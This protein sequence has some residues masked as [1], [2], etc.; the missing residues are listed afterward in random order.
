MPTNL[1][2]SAKPLVPLKKSEACSLKR[3]FS[4][5][6]RQVVSYL[7]ILAGNDPDRFVWIRVG[8]IVKHCKNYAKKNND[9]KPTNYGKSAVEKALKDLRDAGILSY[10]EKV[11]LHIRRGYTVDECFVLAPHAALTVREEDGC[12]MVGP[13]RAPGTTWAA[14]KGNVWYVEKGSKN[15]L[16]STVTFTVGSTVPSTDR[17]MDA[18]TVQSTD[19]ST[20]SNE[21]NGL[22]EYGTEYGHKSGDTVELTEN[23]VEVK[24]VFREFSEGERVPNPS[25]QLV[26]EPREPKEP[27]EPGEPSRETG[28]HSDTSPSALSPHSLTKGGDDGVE[29]N[30]IAQRTDQLTPQETVAQVTTEPRAEERFVDKPGLAARPAPGGT[31]AEH[32]DRAEVFDK[33]ELRYLQIATDGLLTLDRK[34]RDE[35]QR[36]EGAIREAV[37]LVG[38]TP[39]VGRKSLVE[40]LNTAINTGRQK[41]P[42]PVFKVM[43]ELQEK[44]GDTSFKVIPERRDEPLPSGM[45]VYTDGVVEDPARLAAWV[46]FSE[47]D[48]AMGLNLVERGEAFEKIWRE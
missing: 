16:E 30:G 39:M 9:G 46:A 4:G 26:S 28:G 21:K 41:L 5:C 14:I 40:V 31:V 48:A 35:Y 45:V 34:H 2:D 18:S 32:F 33:W 11:Q 47:S 6:A 1:P 36:V 42:R 15:R 29:G 23:S 27:E 22:E 38:H 12:R 44:G 24:K 10:P 7:D 19:A 3:H 20:V 8:E 43:K 13:G 17:S 37:E 25:S